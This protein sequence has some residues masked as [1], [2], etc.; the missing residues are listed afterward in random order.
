VFIGFRGDVPF[1]IDGNQ[2]GRVTI[3]VVQLN[4]RSLSEARLQ[5]L[6]LL[7]RPHEIVDFSTQQL[8]NPDLQKAVT[9]AKTVLEQALQPPAEFTAVAR[10]ASRDNFQFVLD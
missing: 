8:G 9:D 5:R 10:W 1:A 4:R 7:H 3:D 6:Q 2:K